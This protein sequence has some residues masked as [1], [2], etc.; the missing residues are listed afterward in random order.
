MPQHFGVLAYG[1]A[2][3][4]GITTITRLYAGWIDL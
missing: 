1:F 2:A 4:C 3:L